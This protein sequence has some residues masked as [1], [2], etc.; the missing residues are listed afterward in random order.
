MGT[1]PELN[2]REGEMTTELVRQ[3]VHW[4]AEHSES[5]S[6]FISPYPTWTVN[7]HELLDY[8]SSISSIDKEQISKW[9]EEITEE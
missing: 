1:I 8:I 6:S 9:V 3:I 5:E 7:S 2:E 4:I